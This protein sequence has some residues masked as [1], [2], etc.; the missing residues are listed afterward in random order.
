MPRYLGARRRARTHYFPPPTGGW[1]DRD[2]LDDMAQNDAI[3]LDNLI[4]DLNGV[5]LRGGYAD[6]ATGLGAKVET[7]MTYSPADGTDEMFAAAGTSVFDVTSAGA[8]G[9][10]VITSTGNARWSKTMHGTTAGQFLVMC[11]GVVWCCALQWQYMGDG[12]L[13]GRRGR[14][15]SGFRCLVQSAPFLHRE[16][17]DER[18]V[19]TCLFCGFRRGNEGRPEPSDEGGR[20]ARIHRDVV[21]G[22]R[23]RSGRYDLLHDLEGGGHR[24]CR[25]RPRRRG[26][27]VACRCLRHAAPDRRPSGDP[28]RC[29]CRAC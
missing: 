14:G 17:L 29:R 20:Q 1:N 18:L 26:N 24:L 15:G 6:H 27:V 4:P 22:R 21:P 2:A 8:V 23:R 13:Y 19:S 25:H 28:V 3:V 11:N 16:E 5:N 10:A 7:I 12:N 9:A